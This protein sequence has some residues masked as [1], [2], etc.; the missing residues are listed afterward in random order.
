MPAS[1]TEIPHL[2]FTHHR[3]GVHAQKPAAH[4]ARQ[5]GSLKPFLDV[6]R[7]SAIDQKRS[8]GLGYLETANLERDPALADHYR[9]HALD[10]LMSVQKAGL[11]D[12]ALEAGLARLHFDLRLNGVA[13]FARSA[14]N[15]SE[16]SAQDRCNALFQLAD[17]HAK[18]REYRQAIPLLLE[19]TTLRRHPFDWLML[20]DCRKNLDGPAAAIEALE[21]AVRINPRLWKI[22]QHLAEHYRQQGD[23]KKAAW[24]QARAAP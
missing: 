14:L 18:N 8:L 3:I 21:Q 16:I 19:L 22:Q 7:L 23:A 12:P 10:T 1:P 11:R 20:A 24:H 15:Y 13:E 17:E 2:A 9:R 6:S 4:D 5:P